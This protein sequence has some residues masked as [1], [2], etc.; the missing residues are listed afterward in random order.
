MSFASVRNITKTITSIIVQLEEKFNGKTG[1]DMAHLWA[2]WQE[3]REKRRRGISLFK[4]S[5]R[6]KI[7][8]ENSQFSFRSESAML[9]SSKEFRK[10]QRP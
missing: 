7:F 8:C 3:E 10:E 5:K 2:K 6:L 9:C 4:V 1:E